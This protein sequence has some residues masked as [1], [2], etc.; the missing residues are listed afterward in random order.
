MNLITDVLKRQRGRGGSMNH[1]MSLAGHSPTSTGYTIKRHA[2]KDPTIKDMLYDGGN[3]NNKI[4]L[5]YL[6]L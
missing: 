2:E 4:W 6:I 3:L 5:L 1:C